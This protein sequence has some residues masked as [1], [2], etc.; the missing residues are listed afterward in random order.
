[1]FALQVNICPANEVLFCFGLSELNCSQSYVRIDDEPYP[2]SYHSDAD[3]C[4]YDTQ[5]C[6][7][8]KKYN[9]T[10]TFLFMFSFITYLS[11]WLLHLKL[12]NQIKEQNKINQY[13][14][15]NIGRYEPDVEPVMGFAC[16]V[17]VNDITTEPGSDE[18]TYT[19]SGKC[20]QTLCCIFNFGACF[21]LGVHISRYKEEIITDTM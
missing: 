6:I 19:I 8:G 10:Q 13:A 20:K 15:G 21:F 11:M 4:A 17:H 16:F 2:C 9:H 12:R 7:S 18:H 5:E 14:H 3:V 1:M